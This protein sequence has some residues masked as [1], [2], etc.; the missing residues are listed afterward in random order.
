MPRRRTMPNR[1]VVFSVPQSEF[2]DAQM[3]ELGIS[4][5]DVVRRAMDFYIQNQ[6]KPAIMQRLIAEQARLN[7]QAQPKQDRLPVAKRKLKVAA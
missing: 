5:S 4:A 3:E 2:I 1:N 6:I 7:E